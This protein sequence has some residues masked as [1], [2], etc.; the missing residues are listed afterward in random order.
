MR[1]VKWS[2]L[3]SALDCLYGKKEN[4]RIFL[5]L[6]FSFLELVQRLR[7]VGVSLESVSEIQVPN[8]TLG[9]RAAA[10][11]KNKTI[12]KISNF[13]PPQWLDPPARAGA[14]V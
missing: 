13:T 1:K 4:P 3:L 12:S 14:K 9:W 11:R 7:H 8:A 2:G 5:F 6:G 10:T